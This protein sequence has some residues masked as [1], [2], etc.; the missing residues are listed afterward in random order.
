M[1]TLVQLNANKE[2][3]EKSTL[4]AIQAINRVLSTMSTSLDPF[5]YNLF[6]TE[7][8]LTLLHIYR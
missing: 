8:F 5:V 2:L 7:V 4:S 6:Q 1:N 3:Q